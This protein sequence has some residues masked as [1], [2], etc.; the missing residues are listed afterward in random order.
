MEGVFGPFGNLI[1][2]NGGLGLLRRWWGI[3]M[4]WMGCLANIGSRQPDFLCE[5]LLGEESQFG[6]VFFVLLRV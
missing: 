2:A 1:G 6:G 3:T 4:W 5:T